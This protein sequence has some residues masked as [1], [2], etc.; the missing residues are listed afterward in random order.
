MRPV[1]EKRR[2]KAARG[3]EG[4][5]KAMIKCV[6]K[7]NR[8]FTCNLNCL[9]LK[10]NEKEEKPFTKGL[11]REPQGVGGSGKASAPPASV[12]HP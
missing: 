7:L 6:R 5:R 4:N 10:T 8:V 12:L 9:S 1:N 3:T 2:F 11:D